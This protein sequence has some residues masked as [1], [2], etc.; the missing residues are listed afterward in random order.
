MT[1]DRQGKERLYETSE[2]GRDAST[3]YGRSATRSSNTALGTVDLEIGD[4]ARVLRAS[5]LYDQGPRGDKPVS[6]IGP[7]LRIRIVTKT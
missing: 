7:I 6:L 5:R 3:R 2:A 1:A 4:A